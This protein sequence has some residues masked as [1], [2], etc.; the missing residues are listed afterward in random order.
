MK[1]LQFSFILFFLSMLN[2][3]YAKNNTKISFQ[4][5][6]TQPQAHYVNVQMTIQNIDAKTTII[7]MPVWAPGSYL[8]REFS[9]NVEAFK[10][11]S[12]DKKALSFKKITKNAW[13]INTTHVK[14][15]VINYSVYAFEVSV[16][17]SFV[18]ADQ[19][20]LSSPDIFMYVDGQLAKPVSVNIIP[21]VGWKKISTALEPIANKANTFYAS[22][23]DELYDSPIEIGNQ[24]IFYVEEAGVNHEIAMVKGGNYAVEQL[25]KDIANIVKTA[26]A[27]FGQNPNKRYVFI[28][29]NYASGGG[30]LEHKKST[31]LGATRLGYTDEITYKGF[32]SLLAHE[33]FHLWNVKR[34]RPIALGPFDYDKENYT[35]N[36]WIAEGFTAYYENLL[37]LRAGIISPQEYLTELEND[38]NAVINQPG[39]KVQSLSDASFNA[40]IKYYR[41][42]ENSANSS[43][44]YYN[45][46]ALIAAI[47]DITIIHQN[48]G[49]YSLDDVMRHAYN[50][51]YKQLNR[52]YTDAEFKAVLKKYAGKA[53]SFIYN[54]YIN[55]TADIDFSTYLGYAGLAIEDK[56]IG[57]QAPYLGVGTAMIGQNLTIKN[58]ARNSAA[59]IAGLNVNDIII[60]IDGLKVTNLTKLVSEKR[61]GDMLHFLVDR[62]GIEK[63][64]DVTLKANPNKKY[65]INK[66][67]GLT[68]MQTKVMAKWLKVNS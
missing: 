13:K 52:G 5:S 61:V 34:L 41:P 50:L 8:V 64:I 48:E 33:Y 55:G 53:L 35:P 54:N 3:V 57:N 49:K 58:V 11:N 31:V 27:V 22:N 26:T 56:N 28:V 2:N 46:G 23:F 68:D 16:R 19:A 38:I 66:L 42:N 12:T 63:T 36:L 30:G 32:L 60:T 20:F 9:K 7:K 51:Y 39:N 65:V 37:C 25:K 29:H 45:K 17:T 43:I 18:D 15:L 67:E 10:V 6:F 21:L 14:T 44:S 62:D 24:D 47:L 59:Y 40:W 4:I 1:F